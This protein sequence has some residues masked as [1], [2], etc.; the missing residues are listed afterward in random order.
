[1][2]DFHTHIIP[3][4]DDG[5]RNVKETFTLLREAEIAGFD[6]IIS[7]SHYLSGQYEKNELERK[8]LLTA[9]SRIAKKS[10]INIELYLGSEIY[11]DNNIV[12]FLQEGRASSING[13]R[14]VLIE[15]SLQHKPLE[16]KET[17][18]KLLEKKYKPILAHPERYEYVQKDIMYLK[19]LS[20]MGVLFQSNFASF[21][22]RYGNSAKKTAKKLLENDM[23]QFLGSDAHRKDSIYPSIPKCIKEIKKIISEEKFR[24]LSEYNAEKIL[25]NESIEI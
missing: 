11:I 2:I 13:T 8:E 9:I 4:I 20:D 12:D 18:Y 21:I 25:K 19:E 23:V 24:E 16:L 1:M 3:Q 14:Y 17:I 7:T 22:G 15:L 10:G 5:S 6:R